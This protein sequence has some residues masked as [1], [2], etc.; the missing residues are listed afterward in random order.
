MLCDSI[1]SQSNAHEEKKKSSLIMIV[2][3]QAALLFFNFLLN[4]KTFLVPSS[5]PY[6]GI[7]PTLLSPVAFVGASL[8]A[9]QV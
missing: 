4:S 9:L 3:T 6:K 7:P 5:G 8:K 1:S 2:G